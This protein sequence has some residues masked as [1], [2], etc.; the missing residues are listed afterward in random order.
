MLIHAGK[1]RRATFD[2]G[3]AVWLAL[4]AGAANAASFRSLGHF[5]ANMTGNVSTTS[6]ALAIGHL[7][8]AL[9]LISLVVAFVLGSFIS[10]LLIEVGRR[11]RVRG[12]YAVSI[13]L[14]ALLLLILAGVDMLWPSAAVGRLMLVGL[15]LLMGL[16]NAATTR[17]SDGRVRTTHVSGIATDIGLELAALIGRGEAVRGDTRDVVIGRLLLHLA[18][19]GAFFTG[20]VAG[21][22]GYQVAGP[23][24]FAAIAVLLL[25]VALP[26]ARRA[27]AGPDPQEG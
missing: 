4:A 16:Q 8:T 17:I 11:R 14:E 23:L 6:E 13:L 7:G 21:V 26:Q 2:L 25:L 12:I 22:W 18:T 5:S 10:A 1:E 27:F 24:V 3:L 19:L 9:W 15:S 20:G